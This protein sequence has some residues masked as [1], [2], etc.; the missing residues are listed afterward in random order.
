MSIRTSL[1]ALASIAALATTAL[2]PTSASAFWG[3]RGHFRAFAGHSH[4]GIFYPRRPPF[5]PP[6][7]GCGHIG[8]NLYQ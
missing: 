4:L 2:A 1:L 5:L 3:G 8:C 6:I 7:P